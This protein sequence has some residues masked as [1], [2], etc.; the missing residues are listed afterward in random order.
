MFCFPKSRINENGGKGN[1]SFRGQ[2]SLK[3]RDL[4]AT[5]MESGRTTKEKKSSFLPLSRNH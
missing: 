5:K 1:F 4:S 2:K 3:Y